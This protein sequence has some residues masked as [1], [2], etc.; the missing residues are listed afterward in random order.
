MLDQINK[1]AVVFKN[2][3][4][5]VF[6][7]T[8]SWCVW[9][10]NQYAQ[11]TGDQLLNETVITRTVLLDQ[12]ADTQA[13]LLTEVTDLRTDTFDFLN[14]TAAKLDRRLVS[15][16]Q[17]TF[18]RIDRLQQHTETQLATITQNVNKVTDSA[19]Q[20]STAYQAPA[21][22]AAN[23]FKHVDS[24]FNCEFNDL[25]WPKQTSMTLFNIERSAASLSQTVANFNSITPGL[26]KNVEKFSTSFADTAPQIMQ[27]TNKIT[28]NVERLTKPRWYDRMIGWG[29]NGS[30]IYFNLNRK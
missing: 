19:V 22:Q 12:L 5:A 1:Y 18:Q 20:L 3:S 14:H 10:F 8:V 13:H 17:K 24:E 7:Y 9:D 28:N 27:N 30:L 29:L 26:V 15:V 25:C 6:F 23:F 2:V 16:E 11:Y 21:A 4:V